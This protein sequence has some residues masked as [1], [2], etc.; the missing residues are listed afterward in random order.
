MRVVIVGGTGQKLH[1]TDGKL[2]GT[3]EGRK[4]QEKLTI[5]K[6]LE[7]SRA[8]HSEREKVEMGV[9]QPLLSNELKNGV[10][11]S[12]TTISD[13][14]REA[15]VNHIKAHAPNDSRRRD[16]VNLGAVVVPDGEH[17]P[18]KGEGFPPWDVSTG[19]RDKE[20]GISLRADDLVRQSFRDGP[21]VRRPLRASNAGLVL[22]EV[23]GPLDD[24]VAPYVMVRDEKG[25]LLDGSAEHVVVNG[26]VRIGGHDVV[27]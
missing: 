10:V 25:V 2:A 22:Q 11:R 4:S 7:C 19:P 3:V 27:W 16:V 17:H 18:S 5:Q 1:A 13:E 24:D 20:G 15:R 23:D 26:T 9:R 21:M 6:R 12:A 8:A 14:T